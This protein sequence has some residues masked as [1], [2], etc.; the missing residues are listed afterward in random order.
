M[1]KVTLQR[2]TSFH[3]DVSAPAA[4]NANMT[5]LESVIDTLLSR[6]NATPNT[7]SDTLDMNSQRIINLPTPITSHEP[8]TQAQLDAL[9]LSVTTPPYI[10]NGSVVEAHL[11]NGAVTEGKIGSLAVSTGKIQDNAIT[12]VKMADNSVSTAEI[13]NSSVTLA[14][15]ANLAANTVIGNNT[16][17]S[18]A[19]AEITM[20]NLATAL[21]PYFSTAVAVGSVLWF[22]KS[23]PPTGYLVCNGSAVSRVTYATLYAYLCPSATVTADAGT[24]LITWNAHNLQNW[25][26]VMFTTSGTMPTGLSAS[27]FYY[28]RDVTTNTFKVAATAG[29]SVIDLTSAGTGTITCQHSNWGLGDYVTTFNLP[30]LRGEFVRGIDL[31]KG[32]DA[33]RSMADA[34]AHMFQTHIHTTGNDYVYG[35]GASLAAGLGAVMLAQ[36]AT[37]APTTGNTGA[38]TRPRNIALLPCIKF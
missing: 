27:T 16:G 7:M 18:A 6:D 8:V 15:L 17:G 23:S 22:P 4:F 10:T 11:A 29:G 19:P 37:T 33:N 38:E 26:R 24:D 36:S 1:S 13:V 31:G 3:N 2:I 9:V 5:L 21:A 28:V 25:D 34:Q 20:A 14:K 30:D 12:N 32:T 35:V